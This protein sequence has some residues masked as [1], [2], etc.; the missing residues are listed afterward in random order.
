MRIS[1]WSSDV[2]SSD[3]SGSDDRR[4]PHE[5]RAAR[6]Q[7]DHGLGLDLL[8]WQKLQVEAAEDA[9]QDDHR[10]EDGEALAE[11]GSRAVAEGEIRSEEHT[12]ELQSLLRLSYAVFCL[13][14]ISVKPNLYIQKLNMLNT[15]CI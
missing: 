11:A 4:Q 8:P 15:N 5:Q 7:G 10:L 12:S 13:K 2:C 3:L 14:K 6:A 1:D 9:R